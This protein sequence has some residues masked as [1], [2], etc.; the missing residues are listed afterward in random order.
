MHTTHKFTAKKMFEMFTEVL[1]PHLSDNFPIVVHVE[2]LPD[3]IAET[4]PLLVGPQTCSNFFEA[5]DRLLY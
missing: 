3:E 4:I 5:L 2:A 1:E